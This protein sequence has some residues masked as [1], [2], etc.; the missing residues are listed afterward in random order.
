MELMMVVWRAE[1]MV[2]KKEWMKVVQ[3]VDWRAVMWV[4]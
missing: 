4:D 3:T 2:E 1:R